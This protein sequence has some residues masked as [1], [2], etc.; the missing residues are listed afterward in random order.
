V[1]YR[2]F[3]FL[4]LPREEMYPE[5]GCAISEGHGQVRADLPP[6]V[7]RGV[8]AHEVGHLRT[9]ALSSE[10][11]AN[12]YA[13]RV[14]PLGFLAVVAYVFFHPDQR[15]GTMDSLRAQWRR[16]RARPTFTFGGQATEKTD[17]GD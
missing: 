5:L 8:L 6:R 10:I 15:R 2:G 17:T 11:Q 4:I 14:D 9:G 3:E 1:R 16:R 12:L 13:L 7:F